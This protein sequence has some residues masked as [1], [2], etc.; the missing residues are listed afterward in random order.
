MATRLESGNLEPPLAERYSRVADVVKA[1]MEL[2]HDGLPR[3]K[4]DNRARTDYIQD[5]LNNALECYGLEVVEA[6][7]NGPEQRAIR[8]YG[9][10]RGR[11]INP[12][13][14]AD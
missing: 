9:I 3:S 4:P 13:E 6:D 7:P 5:K 11:P 12:D 10:Y 14:L 8:E 1:A 2:L